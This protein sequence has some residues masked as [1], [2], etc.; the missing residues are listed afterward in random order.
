MNANFN[1]PYFH[2][3]RYDTYDQLVDHFDRTFGLGLSPQDR[4]D[5]VAYLQAVGDGLMPYERDGITAQL[6]EINEFAS[7][8]EVAIRPATTK[9]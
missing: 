5:I 9:S 4:T 6:K 3:G 2:D 1:A 8:L 7:V